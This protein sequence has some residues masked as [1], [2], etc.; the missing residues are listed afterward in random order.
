MDGNLYTRDNPKD[1]GATQKDMTH[2]DKLRDKE[3]AQKYYGEKFRAERSRKIDSGKSD[4]DIRHEKVKRQTV[5]AEKVRKQKDSAK[6]AEQKAARERTRSGISEA[7]ARVGA[8]ASVLGD[9]S[10]ANS[11]DQD[12]DESSVAEEA[13]EAGGYV[14][15]GAVSRVTSKT[16]SS[17]YSNKLHKGKDADTVAKDAARER[18]KKEMQRKA[19][20]KQAKAA[21][22][23]GKIGRKI[24]DKAED[25]AGLLAEKIQEFVMDNPV[26]SAIIAGILILILAFSGI[27]NSCAAL[28]SGG[29]DITVATSFTAEDEEILA[30]EDDY[31]ELEEGLQD[32]I[33]DIAEDHADYDEIN[34][35]LDEVGHNPYQLAAILTV[36]FESYTRDEVQSKLQEIFDLQYE[37]SYEETVETRYTE[38]EDEDEDP[39]PYDYYICD[40]YLVNH[41]LDAVVEELGFTEDEMVRYEILLETFGNKK[42]LFGEDDVYNIPG[43]GPGDYD[44]YHVPGEYL[45]DEEFARMLHE[46]ERY[47]G[48]PYVWGGYSPSGFDCSGFVSY[49]INH[50]GN[51]WN[52]GRQTANGL[53]HITANVPSSEA[54]P[55]D[56]IFF[57]GTYDTA[58]ASHVGIYVG[59]GMMIHAGNPIHYSSINT[60]Y[61]QSH[62]LGFGRLP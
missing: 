34:Y 18:M 30:V 36:I 59:N 48:V 27:M 33:D 24:T 62:Y 43:S 22:N 10:G 45:T 16:K 54:K 55:G 5:N 26:I 51:G 58:G 31:K 39:E 2:A 28:G 20:S 35:H 17:K 57:Q 42:Y 13:F 25:L 7:A 4:E 23:T 40:I 49:V 61:W 3:S 56:L 19:A 41:T 32:E 37:V 50:C 47:L 38:P 21:E 12:K 52:V 46:A 60:P 1:K 9:V 44:D 29:G 53:R 15:S 14:A 11:D 8:V 6:K